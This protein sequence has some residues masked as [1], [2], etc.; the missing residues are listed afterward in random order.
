MFHLDGT[1]LGKPLSLISVSNAE[2]L[3]I[4]QFDFSTADV[5]RQATGIKLVPDYM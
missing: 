1:T 2:A 4:A 3:N 5:T